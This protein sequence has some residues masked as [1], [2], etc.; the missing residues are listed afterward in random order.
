MELKTTR[1]NVLN[2]AAKCPGVKRVLEAMFPKAFEKETLP[3][4]DWGGFDISFD[5]AKEAGFYDYKPIWVGSGY[6][7]LCKRHVWKIVPYETLNSDYKLTAIRK[8]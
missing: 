7:M 5:K 8:D 3:V 6:F 1:E 2:E 4:I